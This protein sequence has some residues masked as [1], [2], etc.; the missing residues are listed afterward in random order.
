MVS[1]TPRKFYL[2]ARKSCPFGRRLGGT[3]SWSG[4]FRQKRNVWLLKGI[5]PRIALPVAYSPY[6]LIYIYIYIYI[7]VYRVPP[8]LDEKSQN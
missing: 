1:L 8:M 6:R 5:E 7:Y 2:Q 4:G 3:Q